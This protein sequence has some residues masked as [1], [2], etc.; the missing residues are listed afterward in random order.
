M[1]YLRRNS[2]E[3]AEFLARKILCSWGEKS[4]KRESLC[5]RSSII[6]KISR[7]ASSC[8]TIIIKIIMH[9]LQL[10]SGIVFCM[11][12]IITFKKISGKIWSSR[13]NCLFLQAQGKRR[14]AKANRL[15]PLDFG[16]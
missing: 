5:H 4:R 7:C 6:S 2:G 12:F 10:N 9:T 8:N 15:S 14:M 3:T 1:E 13:L 16:P 11:S